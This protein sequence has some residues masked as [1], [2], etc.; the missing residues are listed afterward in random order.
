LAADDY[1]S[2]SLSQAGGDAPVE[3]FVAWY[4]NQDGGGV[5]SPEVCLPGGGWEIAGLE[6]ILSPVDDGR[7][8]SFSINRAIIQKGT[9]RMLVY[10]WYDQRGVRTSSM[11]EAKKTLMLGKFLDGRSDS[12][13]VR[14]VT[15]IDREEGGEAAAAVRLNDAMRGVLQHLPRFV[16]FE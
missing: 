11:F 4:N 9:H 15:Q 1:L 16:P 6:Q 7:D 2:V 3:L 10:Y 14:F 8:Q 5:H 12:A 13:I